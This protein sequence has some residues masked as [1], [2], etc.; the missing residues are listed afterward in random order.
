MQTQRDHVHAHQFQMTRMSNALV[1]GE[2]TSADN[3]FQRPIVGLLTGIVIAILVMAGFL[4]YGWLK[5]GGNTTWRSPGVIIVEKETGNR[6]VYLGGAL[7]QTRNL[8]SAMLLE[9]PGSSIKLVSR[10]SLKGV[11]HGS[12]IGL[13]AAPQVLPA[14]GSLL[15]G[16]W[17]A[18]LSPG[19]A[20]GVRLDLDPTAPALP[21]G[22]NEF[23][24]VAHNGKTYLLWQNQRHEVTSAAVPIT[25]GATAAQPP[26][27]PSDWLD[28]VPQGDPIGLPPIK[29]LGEDGPTVAG[30]PYKIGQLFVQDGTEQRFALLEDGLAPVDQTAF[31]LLHAVGKDPVTLTAGNLVGARLSPDHS[32]ASFLPALASAK[33]RDP[34]GLS[35]CLRQSPSGAKSV[36]S[37]VV[38]GRRGYSPGA[39][40]AVVKAGTGMIA[41]AVPL[42]SNSGTPVPFL[43]TDDGIKYDVSADNAL[44]SL[45]LGG[46][47]VP[48]PAAFLDEVK[49][50]PAL[51]RAAVTT[52]LEG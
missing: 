14:A 45:G 23:S 7:H 27:A 38:L 8:A 26:D 4:V 31:T 42:A 13:S 16:P 21:L 41:Y 43:I 9:G 33:Y 39:P 1:I 15:A 44:S 36:R 30:H 29:R 49:S 10:E 20:H 35:L 32:L 12:S 52:N 47:E 48:F 22:G 50:G 25:L 19:A 37:E 2:T 17:L 28:Q 46:P 6:Y 40:V 34:A 5:P 3:P 18:C 51:S 11:P 24:L